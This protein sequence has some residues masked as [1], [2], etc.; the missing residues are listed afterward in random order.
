MN[1]L[2]KIILH[3]REEVAQK[4][5]TMP[6][7]F[8]KDVECPEIRDFKSALVKDRM[9]IITEIKERSPSAGLIR[10]NFDP[11]K[12]A[13]I[14][15]RNGA[16]AISIL[17]DNEFFGGCLE[18]LTAVRKKVKIPIL[19]KD[20]IIDDYQIYE[21]LYFGAD[22]VLL[23]ARILTPDVL[24]RF[25]I[26]SNELGLKCFVEV[27]TQD[28]LKK[29]IS[30]EA[31]IIG[32]NNRDLNTLEVDIETSLQLIKMIPERYITV[33]ESGIKTRNDIIRLRDAGFNAVLIGETLMKASDTGQKLS[34][35][36]GKS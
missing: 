16:D 26:L 31:E 32:V 23:I 11:I 36:I 10:R 3:K 1:L 17:T 14:Y 5:R 21:S 4:K 20:F 8:L 22:A 15:E 24:E 29:V 12:I 27:H 9:A 19:R 13:R 30:T 7:K 33:S 18:Y 35:L 6:I 25:I 28:E 2:E 34:E